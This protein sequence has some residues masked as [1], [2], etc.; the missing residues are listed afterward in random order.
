MWGVGCG[1]WGV[2]CGVWGVGGWGWGVGGGGWGVKCRLLGVEGT[3]VLLIEVGFGKDRSD[4]VSGL[5]LRV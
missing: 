2:V 5:G 1:V 4:L 3:C